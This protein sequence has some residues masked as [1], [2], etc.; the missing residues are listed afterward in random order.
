VIA[1]N[2]VV[3]GG[4]HLATDD[5]RDMLALFERQGYETVVKEPKFLD[6][7]VQ[8]YGLSPTWYHLLELRS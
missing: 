6:P 3:K 5:G 7:V 8:E 4:E 1:P 2:A